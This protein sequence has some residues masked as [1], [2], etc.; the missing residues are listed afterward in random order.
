MNQLE[1]FKNLFSSIVD[2]SKRGGDVDLLI[3]S[4]VILEKN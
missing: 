1:I 3:I 2:D 4:N